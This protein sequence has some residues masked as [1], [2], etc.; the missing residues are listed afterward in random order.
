MAKRKPKMEVRYEISV[1]NIT[2]GDLVRKLWE[3]TEADRGQIEEQYDDEPFY[4]IVIDREWE[5]E[6]SNDQ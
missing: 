5:E 6:S 3:A 1:W 2:N 4:E